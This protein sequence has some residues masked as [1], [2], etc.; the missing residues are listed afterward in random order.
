M[1][2]CLGRDDGLEN[3]QGKMEIGLNVQGK[4]VRNEE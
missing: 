3:W 4:L 2:R 1:V